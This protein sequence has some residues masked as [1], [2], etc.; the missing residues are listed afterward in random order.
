MKK[1]G[2]GRTTNMPFEGRIKD[3]KTAHLSPWVY[4]INIANLLYLKST[5]FR[6]EHNC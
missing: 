5:T 1:L 2:L 3:N 6:S 4:E